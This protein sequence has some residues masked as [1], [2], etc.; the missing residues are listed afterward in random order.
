MNSASQT[1][2]RRAN[3][4]DDEDGG[5]DTDADDPDASLEFRPIDPPGCCLAATDDDADADAD[6]SDNAGDIPRV[7]LPWGGR[8]FRSGDPVTDPARRGSPN[9]RCVCGRIVGRWEISGVDTIDIKELTEEVS[10]SS[11]PGGGGGT[12]PD[13]EPPPS[14]FLTEME[15]ERE[16][17]RFAPLP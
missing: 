8:R 2:H 10:E 5:T 12:S 1:S 13:W 9:L 4:D 7:I 11:S 6:G 17:P 14:E 3:G 15:R 16:D